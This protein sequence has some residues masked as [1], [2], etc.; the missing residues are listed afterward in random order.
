MASGQRVESSRRRSSSNSAAGMATWNSRTAGPDTAGSSAGPSRRAASRGSATT[1]VTDRDARDVTLDLERRDH[2]DQNCVLLA[3]GD[4]GI[5]EL[6]TSDRA[7][8]ADLHRID[9][10]EL[11]DLHLPRVDGVQLG[12]PPGREDTGRDERLPNIGV[13]EEQVDRQHERARG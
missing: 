3:A 2:V 8:E 1:R 10:G 6:T 4:V 7:R 12:D 9:V 5:A 13:G 11:E